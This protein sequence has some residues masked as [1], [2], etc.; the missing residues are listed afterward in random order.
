VTFL[1]G[2]NRDFPKRRRHIEVELAITAKA[3]LSGS[4]CDY[5]FNVEYFLHWYD[6]QYDVTPRIRRLKG[7]FPKPSTFHHGRNGKSTTRDF[8]DFRRCYRG[9]FPIH[10]P[11][12]FLPFPLLSGHF[13]GYGAALETRCCTM[14]TIIPRKRNDGSIGYMAQVRVKAKDKVIH[15]ETKTFDRKQHPHGWRVE[16]PSYANPALLSD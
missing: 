8:V 15:T 7:L 14:G 4:M 6:V 16:R 2:A 11:F 3:E 10:G 1:T 9:F 13:V 5:F 12:H